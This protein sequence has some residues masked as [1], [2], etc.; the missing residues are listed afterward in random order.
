MKGRMGVMG[1]LNRRIT[2]LRMGPA[3]QQRKSFPSDLGRTQT[4]L[5]VSGCEPDEGR[6]RAGCTHALSSL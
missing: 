3:P 4:L 1:D 5:Q 2:D 6:M